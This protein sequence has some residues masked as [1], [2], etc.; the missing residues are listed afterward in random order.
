MRGGATSHHADS[1]QGALLAE[2]DGF[3]K[4]GNVA[5]IAATNRRD[6]LDAAITSRFQEMDLAVGRP[7]RAAAESI[8]RVHLPA[9]LPFGSFIL[10]TSL[11]S[12]FWPV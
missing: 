9:S 8:F 10:A 6:I 12:G 4:R 3:E 11:F 7:K 5:I 1:A 2:I